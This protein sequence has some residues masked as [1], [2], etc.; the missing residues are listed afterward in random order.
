MLTKLSIPPVALKYKRCCDAHKSIT[1][2]K[3]FF[4]KQLSFTGYKLLPDKNTLGKVI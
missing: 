1:H 4:W 3:Y 2:K